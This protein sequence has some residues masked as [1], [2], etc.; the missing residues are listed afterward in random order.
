MT[1]VVQSK[2]EITIYSWYTS[3]MDILKTPK[4]SDYALIDSGNGKRLEKFGTYTLVRPDPQALWSPRLDNSVWEKVDAIFDE[5]EKRGR[6]VFQS[7]IPDRWEMGWEG[8]RFYA[9][10]SPFKHTGVFPEQSVNWAWMQR[11]LDTQSEKN[12]LN[13]FGYTGIASLVC[14]AAGAKV[15]HVDASK[16]TIGWAR[17]NQTLSGLQDKPIRW[18]LD[19]A[20]K[21]VSRE[22]KRGIKYDGI[23][24]DP[25]VYG[26]GPEGEPW[27]FM[28][29]F[30]ELL[31]TCK[32]ALSD[33]PL[34]VLINA[35]AVSVS[36]IMLQNMLEDHMNQFNGKVESGELVLQQENSDR[37]L[38]T[39]IFGRWSR[40]V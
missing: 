10:L 21:F 22:I 38:S 12:V 25:P 18:I 11:L 1:L 3:A 15:T 35:Y 2:L 37:L 40:T 32:Q 6:W 34:F 26:H 5:S 20:V 7:R 28:K 24:M 30:P 19:D 31:T 14:A 16:P 13:L 36:S 33:K 17:E 39:G 27:D 23:I 9:K 4:W 29:D 8:I